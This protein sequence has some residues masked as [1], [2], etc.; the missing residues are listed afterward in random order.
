MSKFQAE[1]LLLEYQDLIVVRI[2]STNQIGESAFSDI[3]NYGI[4][5]QTNPLAPTEPLTVIGYDEQSIQLQLTAL[6]GDETGGSSILYYAIVW[7]MGS[8]GSLWDTYTTMTADSYFVNVN[9]LSSG[10]PYR[11]KYKAQNIHG[12]GTESPEVM[13][14]AMS[15]PSASNIPTTETEGANVRINWNAPY[16][17][18]I[19]IPITAYKILIKNSDGD[20]IED[21]D[22][23]DGLT[24]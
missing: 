8:E 17:G 10:H 12:W 16:S 5:V 14:T 2:S 7:D 4:S 3:N 18:G 13:I 9:G 6:T 22:N 20:F 24:D 1:P 21:T 19:G 11:F 23:C 15:Y